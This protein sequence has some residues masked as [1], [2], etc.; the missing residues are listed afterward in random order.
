MNDININ[1]FNKLR[2]MVDRDENA[3]VCYWYLDRAPADGDDEPCPWYGYYAVL[4]VIGVVSL[5]GAQ[6][7]QPQI[8]V[9]LVEITAV[10]I[11]VAYCGR[12]GWYWWIRRKLNATEPLTSA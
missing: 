6:W 8:T 1:T 12:T 10:G 7:L 5:A 9:P 3:A 2:G 11:L 4:S